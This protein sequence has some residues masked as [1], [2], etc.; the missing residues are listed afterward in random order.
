MWSSNLTKNTNKTK[1]QKKKRGDWLFLIVQKIKKWLL[2]VEG[3]KH[4]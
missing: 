3:F 4:K 1:F 2:L